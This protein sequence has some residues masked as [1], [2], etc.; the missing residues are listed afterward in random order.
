ME[1]AKV[2]NLSQPSPDASENSML[3]DEDVRTEELIGVVQPN[4][5]APSPA[6]NTVDGDDGEDD[7]DDFFASLA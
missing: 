1:P 3:L 6:G 7:L 4:I 5:A 2:V